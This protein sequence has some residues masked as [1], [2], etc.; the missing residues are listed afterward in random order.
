[1]KLKPGWIY[2]VKTNWGESFEGQ[3]RSCVRGVNVFSALV[4][5]RSEVCPGLISDEDI[6]WVEPVCEM[7]NALTERD[8]LESISKLN[9]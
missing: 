5:S 4:F 7:T 9:Q 1:M 3:F 6:D 8:Y 2:V